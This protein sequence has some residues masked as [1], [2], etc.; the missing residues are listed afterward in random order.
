MWKGFSEKTIKSFTKL[1]EDFVA[2]KGHNMEQIMGN[3]NNLIASLAQTL[4][5]LCMDMAWDIKF[6]TNNNFEVN[7]NVFM[8]LFIFFDHSMWDLSSPTKD[9]THIPCTGSVE[10]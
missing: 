3:V 2:N 7:I 8:C 10:S 5:Q 1:N 9:G 6:I 4:S